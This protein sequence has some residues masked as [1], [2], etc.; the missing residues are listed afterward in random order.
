MV[1][2]ESAH[3]ILVTSA[4]LRDGSG[5]VEATWQ[6][7]EQR[8]GAVHLPSPPLRAAVPSPFDYAAAIRVFI[9]TNVRREDLNQ[10]AAGA[11]LVLFLAAS[12]DAL[13][14]VHGRE[15]SQGREHPSGSCSTESTGRAPGSSAQGPAGPPSSLKGMARRAEIWACCDPGLNNTLATLWG[16]SRWRA[17]LPERP[18][19]GGAGNDSFS[20]QADRF[21]TGSPLNRRPRLLCSP[22]SANGCATVFCL[23]Q[24]AQECCKMP[25]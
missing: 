8:T 16:L 11:Y 6:A 15:P 24:E 4:I 17:G 23:H 2:A 13:G 22:E 21:T 3:G 9:V 14:L 1:V 25:G 19:R 10:V 5:D 7:A 18:S 12:G 20:R